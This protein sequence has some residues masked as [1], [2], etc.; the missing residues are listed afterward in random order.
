M[1]A[2][3][4]GVSVYYIHDITL[5]GVVITLF[6]ALNMGG[7]VGFLAQILKFASAKVW[8]YFRWEGR[9]RVP[10]Q[11]NTFLV[12]TDV[13]RRSALTEWSD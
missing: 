8:G 13:V 5:P 1:L 9:G 7:E 11:S 10:S 3:T 4:S 6:V 12:I 2:D